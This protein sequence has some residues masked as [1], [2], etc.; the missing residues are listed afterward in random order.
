MQKIFRIIYYFFYSR[1]LIKKYAYKRKK[2]EDRDTL[3]RIILPYILS[4][5]NPKTILDV[6][7]EDYQEFYNLFFINK[8]FWTID[9]DPQKKEFG[10]QNHI[11]DNV[12]NLKKYFKDNYFDFILINGV[13][14][15]GLN[16]KNEIQDTFNILY[17]ILK[18]NGIII[19]GWNDT[20]IP[21]KN[22]EGLNKLKKYYFKPLKGNQFEC[23]NGEHKYNFYIKNK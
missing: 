2:Y 11:T 10:S 18:P 6:G 3:E 9:I 13:L 5:K 15:W 21:L 7:R 22:I 23:I 16:K 17:D 19:V 12:I 4:R 8:E 14:G 1:Y 20:P